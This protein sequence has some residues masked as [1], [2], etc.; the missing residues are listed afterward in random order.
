MKKLILLSLLVLT[1]CSVANTP[2]ETT[3]D[4]SPSGGTELTQLP[5]FSAY[6]NGEMLFPIEGSYC[7]QTMCVDK[8]HPMDQEIDYSEFRYKDGDELIVKVEG[9][10]SFET[11]KFSLMSS[12]GVVLD[13]DLMV[14]P[15]A[16]EGSYKI[17][18]DLNG[19]LVLLTAWGDFETTEMTYYFPFTIAD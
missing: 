5:H 15:Q 1:S 11:L 14:E 10:E 3:P 16:E 9:E 8:I 12:E 13:E 7:N 19:E 17:I 18:D 2:N 4:I 6:I